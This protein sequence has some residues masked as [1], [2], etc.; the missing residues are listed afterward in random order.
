MNTHGLGLPLTT[1]YYRF[2]LADAFIVDSRGHGNGDVGPA[3]R[4]RWFFSDHVPGVLVQLPFRGSEAGFRFAVALQALAAKAVILTMLPER[5][6]S[7]A[8]DSTAR[9][10]PLG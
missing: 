10:V 3:P 4:Q 1:V 5:R 6:Q 9:N 7:A 2:A 8:V